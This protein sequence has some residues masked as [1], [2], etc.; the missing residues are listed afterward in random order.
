LPAL[1]AHRPKPID[2]PD[3]RDRAGERRRPTDTIAAF[4][5]ARV[6][7]ALGQT[8]IIENVGGASGTIATGRVARADPDGYT[9]IIGGVNHFRRQRRGLPAELRS[10]EGL[11]PISMLRVGADADLSRNS[12]PATNLKELLVWLKAN[13]DTVTFGT[14]GLRAH[15]TSPACRCRKRPA[16]SFSSYRSVARLRHCQSVARGQLTS[17]S[18]RLRRAIDRA[19]AVA[20]A[21]TP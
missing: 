14:G 6:Q 8:V 2:T 17:S 1:R 21:P 12:L 5:M 20:H 13:P 4:V 18:T 7:Q 10:V 19:P 15:R 9:L 3:Q 11:S 16:T